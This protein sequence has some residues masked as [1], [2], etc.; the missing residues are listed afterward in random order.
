MKKESESV[1]LERVAAWRASGQ[2][3]KAFCEGKSYSRY[4][5]SD[6]ARKFA[7]RENP[8]SLPRKVILTEVVRT[9]ERKPAEAFAI[10][11]E[12][13]SLRVTLDSRSE[14]GHLSNVLRALDAL[15]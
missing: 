7:R 15:P 11:V 3:Q 1:W 5:I 6:W 8:E 2:T 12:R 14:P 10:V 9:M 13:N 4:S